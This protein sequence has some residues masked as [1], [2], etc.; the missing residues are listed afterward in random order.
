MIPYSSWIK[1]DFVTAL[2]GSEEPKTAVA[3]LKF[4][5]SDAVW[6]SGGSEAEIVVL[7]EGEE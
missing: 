2:L 4:R 1:M 3:L 6:E 7:V 5:D